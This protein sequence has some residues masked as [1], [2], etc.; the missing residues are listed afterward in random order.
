MAWSSETSALAAL[1][2]LWCRVRGGDLR[3]VIESRKLDVMSAKP[4]TWASD[5]SVQTHQLEWV[6]ER[7]RLRG[8]LLDGARNFLRQ[9]V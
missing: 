3:G 4:L 2:T 5:T 6:R 9:R 7:Q 8:C 1:W